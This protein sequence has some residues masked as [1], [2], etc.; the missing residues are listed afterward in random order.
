MNEGK[1]SKIRK[2]LND[3]FAGLGAISGPLT[4]LMLLGIMVP[5]ANWIGGVAGSIVASGLTFWVFL[6]DAI[7]K[8]NDSYSLPT[9][10]F[11]C[12]VTRNFCNFT[13]KIDFYSIGPKV[14][15]EGL[16]KWYA[17]SFNMYSL[18]GCVTVLVVGMIV[19]ALTNGSDITQ[20]FPHLVFWT[21]NR[22][23]EQ[24]RRPIRDPIGGK[25]KYLV[26]E[27]HGQDSFFNKNDHVFF[28]G[29]GKYKITNFS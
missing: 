15:P 14:A 27:N 20:R 2:F 5:W 22:I 6:G 13:E 24:K 17:L 9:T 10:N 7:F 18:V 12:N 29:A 23:L 4:G 25:M 16:M 11:C 8:L 21:R 1:L 28:T 19:S 3:F 26:S